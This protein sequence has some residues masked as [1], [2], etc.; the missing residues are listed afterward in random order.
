M[1]TLQSP[2]KD[3]GVDLA[4][5]T[6][7]RAHV[8]A[9][10]YPEA[11]LAKPAELDSTPRPPPNGVTRDEV[12]ALSTSSSS[13]SLDGMMRTASTSNQESTKEAWKK[14]KQVLL[15]EARNQSPANLQL[16]GLRPPPPHSDAY[17]GLQQQS[18]TRPLQEADQKLVGPSSGMLSA[19][20]ASQQSAILRWQDPNIRDDMLRIIDQFLEEEGMGATR[21]ILAEEWSGKVRER[22]EAAGDARKLK[23]AILG[24]YDG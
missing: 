1:D 3:K 11:T 10:L 16:H 5:P 6:T 20:R 13:L 12:A 8:H 21:H 4:A 14:R 17:L 24:V 9:P 2:D 19:A 22:D 18:Q 15:A 7:P 23:K